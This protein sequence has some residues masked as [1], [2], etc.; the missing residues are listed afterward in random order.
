MFGVDGVTMCLDMNMA[1]VSVMFVQQLPLIA[2]Q[3]S[4]IV[5]NCVCVFASSLYF[6]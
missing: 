4:I 2:S 1:G 3:S 5:F 6:V